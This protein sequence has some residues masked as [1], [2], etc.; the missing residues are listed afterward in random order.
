MR[1]TFFVANPKPFFRRPA[2]RCAGDCEKPLGN[3][4]GNPTLARF[5][6]AR[7]AAERVGPGC[8][9]T[10]VIVALVA[11][12]ARTSSLI[13]IPLKH[14]SAPRLSATDLSARTQL[15]CVAAAGVVGTVLCP[16]SAPR[17]GLGVSDCERMITVCV[18]VGAHTVR[19]TMRG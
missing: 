13:Q 17:D 15:E 10:L 12:S 7:H 8:V 18:L 3:A 11:S 1:T 6:Q 19:P 16:G 4:E 2:S 5:G 14:G 9:G